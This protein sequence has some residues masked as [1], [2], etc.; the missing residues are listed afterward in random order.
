VA[1]ARRVLSCLKASLA[2][3]SHLLLLR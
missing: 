3:C 2:G 1:V